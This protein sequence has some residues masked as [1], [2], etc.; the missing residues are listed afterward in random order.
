MAFIREEFATP[1]YILAMLF[2]VVN[3]P[4]FY[5][6]VSCWDDIDGNLLDL[7]PDFFFNKIQIVG[8]L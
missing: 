6:P 3:D 1:E 8:L 4:N 5:C 7:G 2:P